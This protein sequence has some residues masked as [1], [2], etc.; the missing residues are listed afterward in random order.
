[1]HTRDIH[2]H[3]RSPATRPWLVAELGPAQVDLQRRL[4]AVFDPLG[5]LAPDGFLSDAETTPALTRDEVPA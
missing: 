2:H 3:P 1:P 4:K 5:L